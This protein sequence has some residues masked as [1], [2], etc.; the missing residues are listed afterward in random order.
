MDRLSF[1]ILVVITL[2]GV[3]EGHESNNDDV[4]DERT[5]TKQGVP[6]QLYDGTIFYPFRLPSLGFPPPQS[7]W[8]PF[9]NAIDR[10]R[11]TTMP[12]N[13]NSNK[14][15]FL[16]LM[17]FNFLN[18]ANEATTTAPLTPEMIP[19]DSGTC[20]WEPWSSC[21][22]VCRGT[23]SRSRTC[24]ANTQSES[25]LCNTRTGFQADGRWYL[26][27]NCY[28]YNY[29]LNLINY[30]SA[31]AECTKLGARLASTGLRED[32]V[33]TDILLNLAKIHGVTVSG[34]WV[35]IIRPTA[36]VYEWSDG[37]TGYPTFWASDEPSTSSQQCHYV[38]SGDPWGLS[39]SSCASSWY[40][41]C[42]RAVQ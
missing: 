19:T 21:S 20:Q 29:I 38:P 3:Q 25:E 13:S 7:S 33:R 9:Q 28:E 2:A 22:A 6:G 15:L 36:G 17:I 12:K 16:M 18:A 5:A 30:D 23:R 35:G 31:K 4:S 42:E 1:C 37:Y 10:S 40:I 11:P 14:F 32:A 27:S 24:S 34:A 26:A 39:D 41:L 8:N